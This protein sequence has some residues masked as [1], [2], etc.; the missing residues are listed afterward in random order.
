MALDLGQRLSTK[1]TSPAPRD[2]WSELARNSADTLVFQT[3]TWFEAVCA[4]GGYT[5]ASR[6][7]ELSGG[8]QLVLPLARRR[9]MPDAL[10]T[11]ASLP[12][13]WGAG[14]IVSRLPL[15]AEDVS[16]VLADL[17]L[18]RVLRTTIRP[19]PLM[20]GVWK[21][22]VPGHIPSSPHEAHVL[23]LS[24][25]FDYVWEKRLPGATR[26]KI[27]KAEKAGL[28]VE[29]DTGGKLIPA[30]YDLYMRWV[31][32]RARERR[33]PVALARWLGRR[34]EPYAKYAAAA[35]ALGEGCR[36]WLARLDG[37]PVAAT[38]LLVSGAHAVYWRSA[39]DKALATPTR[40]NDLLQRLMIEDACRAGCQHYHMGESGGVASLMHFKSRFGAVS[41]AYS[42]Y[43]LERLPITRVS[44]RVSGLAGRLRAS[45]PRR[46]AAVAAETA[47]PHQA[48]ASEAD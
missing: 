40:A 22:A 42:E 1:T 19:S 47:A 21:E 7:Y 39:S 28:T 44:R 2:V 48:Q 17:S 9:G 30:F 26:T 34:R 32:R 24:G 5:D 41:Y 13:G 45:L 36:V 35:D 37:K 14:G 12:H 33:V 10:A 27:R 16:T 23:D 25:G 46:R 6:L 3:P 4:G 29:R 15:R 18:R 8:Q 38:I 43:T 11:E 20:A 31:D